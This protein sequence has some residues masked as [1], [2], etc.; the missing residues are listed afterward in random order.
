MNR[1]DDVLLSLYPYNLEFLYKNSNHIQS[2][3]IFETVNDPEKGSIDICVLEFLDRNEIN[4]NRILVLN[5]KS[6]NQEVLIEFPDEQ[7][8]NIW[9]NILRV[10]FNDCLS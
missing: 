7:E 3:S 9:Y 6:T 1:R 8:M 2:E 10:K 4:G 5:I